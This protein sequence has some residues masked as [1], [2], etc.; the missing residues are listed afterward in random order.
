MFDLSTFM[1]AEYD[2]ERGKRM[3]AVPGILSSKRCQRCSVTVK[4]DS[5]FYSSANCW[6]NYPL[7]R[8]NIVKHINFLVVNN[9]LFVTGGYPIESYVFLVYLWRLQWH[10]EDLPRRRVVTSSRPGWGKGNTN[11]RMFICVTFGDGLAPTQ[12]FVYATPYGKTGDATLSY[13]Y[14]NLLFYCTRYYSP[15]LLVNCGFPL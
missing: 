9:P 11:P 10:C 2:E 15:S 6:I 5:R 8:K 13:V 4:S 7:T 14:N 1:W 3:L 12:N